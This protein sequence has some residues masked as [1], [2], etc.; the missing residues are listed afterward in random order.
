M[1][2]KARRIDHVPYMTDAARLTGNTPALI[3]PAYKELH[4]FAGHRRDV[5]AARFLEAYRN[6]DVDL[7]QYGVIKDAPKNGE[8]I[9]Y[10]EHF[11]NQKFFYDAPY[12]FVLTFSDGCANLGL[13]CASFTVNALNSV[14]IV[15]LQGF[16]EYEREKK[17]YKRRLLRPIRWEKMF[18]SLVADWAYRHGAKWIKVQPVDAN[19]HE[20]IRN[21]RGLRRYNKTA[22]E[23][24]F[25][26]RGNGLYYR[27]LPF[28]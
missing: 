5:G 15:Q 17:K 25:D 12:A 11:T 27:R 18:I 28:G 21:M 16:V 23:M 19:D 3:Q 7:S 13:A 10:G 9:G 8:R 24:W 14:K 26:R 1:S 22:E 6:W 2:H 20:D 4:S